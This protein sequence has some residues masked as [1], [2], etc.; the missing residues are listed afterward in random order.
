MNKCHVPM[1]SSFDSCVDC[2]LGKSHSLPFTRSHTIYNSYLQLIQTDTWDHASTLSSNVFRYYVIILYA[3]STYTWLYLLKYKSDVQVVFR[4]FNT[5]A[6]LQ[7]NHKIHTLQTDNAKEFLALAP[8][9][10]GCGIQLRHSC[11]QPSV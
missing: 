2:P 11:P 1:I 5:Q 3:F 4:N 7:L 6:E 8:F 10:Q 9:L